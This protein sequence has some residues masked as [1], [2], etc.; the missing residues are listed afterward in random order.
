MERRRILL[1]IAAIVAVLGAILVVLYVHSS[2]DRAKKSYDFESVLVAT[3]AIPAGESYGDATDQGKIDVKQVVTQDVV[4]GAA[5][6]VDSIDRSQVAQ[7]TI[8]PGQQIVTQQFGAVSAL[9]NQAVT[10][11]ELPAGDIAISL[12]L[13]DPGRVAGFVNQGSHVAIF[14]TSPTYSRILLPNVLVIGVGS[15]A[16][17]NGSTTPAGA[18]S[19]STTDTALPSTLLTI[20]VKQSDAQKVLLAQQ[21]APANQLS[22]GLLNDKSKIK[23]QTV[24]NPGNLFQ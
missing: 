12:S 24:A 22:F 20:A 16:L 5:T 14:A 4:A 10:N 19:G 9:P 2:D 13:T 6:S 23:K 1:A 7:G 18:T 21:A 8:F 11:L 3:S 17:T 15:S